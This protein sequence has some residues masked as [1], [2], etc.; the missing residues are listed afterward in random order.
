MDSVSKVLIINLTK[1]DQKQ[2]RKIPIQNV[3]HFNLKYVAPSSCKE[4]N[5]I[6]FR[7]QCSTLQL[8]YRLLCLYHSK[9][10]KS[11]NR[12]QTMFQPFW[13]RKQKSTP[14]LLQIRNSKRNLEFHFSFHSNRMRILW[15]YRE[16]MQR[17]A[18]YV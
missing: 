11:E 6:D 2:K 14:Y 12:G 18:N 16:M 9:L 10:L 15:F 1:T 7:A 4:P 17:A 8:K 3:Y 5:E 13:Y